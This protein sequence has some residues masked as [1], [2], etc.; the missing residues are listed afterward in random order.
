M[1]LRS[2]LTESSDKIHIYELTFLGSDR[3]DRINKLI[4]FIK[5][6]KKG[7]LIFDEIAEKPGI[8]SLKEINFDTTYFSIS[9]ETN[10][11]SSE[12]MSN[13]MSGK[14]TIK[15]DNEYDGK[16]LIDNLKES[17]I[18]LGK[19]GNGGHTFDV[20]FYSFSG[21]KIPILNWDGDGNDRINLDTIKEK[22]K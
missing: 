18:Y 22:E 10:S 6:G 13:K 2:L 7:L 8:V 17:L 15:T 21:K 14:I 12:K 19:F 16:S 1:N 11:I 9:Y 4:N 5:K 20:T 3:D